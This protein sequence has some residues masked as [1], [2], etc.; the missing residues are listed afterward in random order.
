MRLPLFR[1]HPLLLP[2][3]MNEKEF[4]LSTV[5]K[6]SKKSVTQTLGY[7]LFQMIDF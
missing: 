2:F 1:L 4:D 6:H 3:W 5:K 7:A